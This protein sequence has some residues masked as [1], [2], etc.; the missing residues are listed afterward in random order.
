MQT[1]R[2]LKELREKKNISMDKMANDLKKYG[3]SPSK[4][5]ISR[6]ETGKAEPSMEYARVLARYFSVSLD[7][8]LGLDSTPILDTNLPDFDN[9]TEA[10]KFILKQPA[11]MAYGGYDIEKMSDEELIGIA[12]DILL[13]I[14][15]SAERRKKK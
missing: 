9:P 12:N 15:I 13:T 7:Y 3:V 14:R 6:W 10:L 8:L 11:L 5:M 1:S 4:S 2:I